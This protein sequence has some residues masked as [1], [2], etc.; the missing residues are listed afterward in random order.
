MYSFFI[1]CIIHTGVGFII[2]ER[3][4]I[5]ENFIKK[6]GNIWTGVVGLVTGL[7]AALNLDDRVKK[8]QRRQTKT[9]NNKTTKTHKRGAVCKKQ[10]SV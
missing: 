5:V 8:R 3:N 1:G 2:L 4:R 6:A 9:T 10:M 7:D